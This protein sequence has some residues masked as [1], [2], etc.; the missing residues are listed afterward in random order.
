MHTRYCQQ[1]LVGL[2]LLFLLL[3]FAHKPLFAQAI[4]SEDEEDSAW[5]YPIDRLDLVNKRIVLGD[6]EGVLRNNFVVVNRTGQRLSSSILKVGL[7]V[8]VAPQYQ[9]N[10]LIIETYSKLRFMNNV[11]SVTAGTNV[12]PE[13]LT[14]RLVHG[15]FRKPM[16]F[17]KYRRL[18]KMKNETIYQA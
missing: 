15:P 7:L 13:L 6:L 10:Q 4:L 18:I 1:K 12:I 11:I 9:G 17:I 16:C 14:Y 2:V 8:S 5:T 3:G